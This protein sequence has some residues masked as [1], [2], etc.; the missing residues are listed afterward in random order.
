MPLPP[1]PLHPRTGTCGQQHPAAETGPPEGTDGHRWPRE[2]TRSPSGSNRS[3]ERGAGDAQR[4]GD[5]LSHAPFPCPA[6]GPAAPGTEIH[7]RVPLSPRPP[8]EVWGGGAG[9]PN[10]SATRNPAQPAAGAVPLTQAQGWVPQP[11]TPTPGAWPVRGISSPLFLCLSFPLCTI[12]A[13]PSAAAEPGGG[14]TRVLLPTSFSPGRREL[15]S[16]T[17]LEPGPRLLLPKRL[18]KLRGHS[19]R[20]AKDGVGSPDPCAAQSLG[21]PAQHPI[22]EASRS[23]GTSRK[24]IS[25]SFS[26]RSPTGVQDT[27]LSDYRDL[28]PGGAFR[29]ICKQNINCFGFYK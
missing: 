26:V 17:S 22:A 5:G 2:G 1:R 18:K 8:S 16:S 24:Q 12:P 6:P 21:H 20:M 25:P 27:A 29:L 13:E 10:L 3:P 4:C 9:T 23:Q 11:C 15:S 28:I 14:S 19:I 7:Q